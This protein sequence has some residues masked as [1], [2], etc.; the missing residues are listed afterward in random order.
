MTRPL[1]MRCACGALLEAVAGEAVAQC[2]SCGRGTEWVQPEVIADPEVIR[3]PDAEQ[4]FPCPTCG[5]SFPFAEMLRRERILLCR[6]CATAGFIGK[7]L[8][9]PGRRRMLGAVGLLLAGSMIGALIVSRTMSPG[10]EV[11]AP[12]SAPTPHAQEASQEPTQAPLPSSTS[13]M[14][15]SSEASPLLPADVTEAPTDPESQPVRSRPAPDE[16]EL[17]LLRRPAAD[18]TALLVA[19]DTGRAA[20]LIGDDWRELDLD[21]LGLQ[22]LHDTCVDDEGRVWMAG[23]GALLRADTLTSE[24]FGSVQGVPEGSISQVVQT[25]DGRV[26]L[27]SWG[28]GVAYFEGDRWHQLRAADGLVNDEA[29][30][31]AF[32]WNRNLWIGTDA[33]VSVLIGT[34]FVDETIVDQMSSLNVKAITNDREGRLFFGTTEGLMILHPRLVYEW[35]GTDDGL[36]APTPQ[37]LLIDSQDRIWAGTWGGGVV[38]ISTDPFEVAETNA[39]PQANHVGALCEDGDGNVWAASLESGL[40]CFDDDSWKPVAV[41]EGFTRLRVVGAIPATVAERLAAGGSVPESMATVEV[42]PPG[43]HTAPTEATLLVRNTFPEPVLVAVAGGSPFWLETGETQSL[44]LRP[45]SYNVRISLESGAYSSAS[46]Q[47]IPNAVWRIGEDLAGSRFPKVRVEAPASTTATGAAARPVAVPVINECSSEV[48][49]RLGYEGR[50]HVLAPGQ[51]TTL[52]L[53]DRNLIVALSTRGERDTFQIV[54]PVPETMWRIAPATD[55]ESPHLTAVPREAP[56]AP[57]PAGPTRTA[58]A[59]VLEQLHKLLTDPELEQLWSFDA[60]APATFDSTGTMLVASGRDDDLLA[61]DITTGELRWQAQWG[62]HLEQLSSAPDRWLWTANRR[63]QHLARWDMVTGKAAGGLRQRVLRA[64]GLAISADGNVALF[65]ADDGTLIPC[66]L[67]SG[68][69]L[70]RFGVELERGVLRTSVGLSADGAIALSGT[71][72]GRVLIWP[73]RT[74]ASPRTLEGHTGWVNALLTSPEGRWGAS[75]SG[76]YVSGGSTSLG[77]NSSGQY[78]G[79]GV[80]VWDVAT[81]ASTEIGRHA[82]PVTS[83]AVSPDGRMLLSGGHDGRAL[84]WDVEARKQLASLNPQSGAVLA[85]GFGAGGRLAFAAGAGGRVVVWR[86]PP[87]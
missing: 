29:N 30:G 28:T 73:T 53:T 87:S 69:L 19:S 54:Q 51:E 58:S 44:E 33:G 55:A 3:A 82:A 1:R 14:L 46:S 25:P 42:A 79:G 41:P 17:P 50:Y 6:T 5:E 24:H 76:H 34:H 67:A 71:S 56:V 21:Q 62:P 36:P 10:V 7:V 35:I 66:D 32:D 57:V 13:E 2:P 18:E 31:I 37:A 20:I 15:R 12:A 68:S 60:Q 65:G 85:V 64:G 81:G 78:V 63:G 48:T 43:S 11:V 39:L 49:L 59:S 16:P 26:L 38:R 72:D 70:P 9:S 52:Q 74:S 47:A 8:R 61:W 77:P 40:W 84:L 80:R 23:D 75:G 86:L 4:L 83:L 45:A 27:C 22:S